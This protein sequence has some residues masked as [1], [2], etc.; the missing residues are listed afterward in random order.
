MEKY[1]ELRE[2]KR[3]ISR[4]EI[5]GHKASL[6]LTAF[7]GRTSANTF[8]TKKMSSVFNLL[9]NEG[10]SHFLSLVEDDEFDN[11]CGK[12]VL[13]A[14]AKKRLINWVHL[15]IGD[16][17]IPKN[18]TLYGLNKIRPQLLEAINRDLSI[19]IHC[20]GGLG[21]SGT[22]AAIIL[23]D[24]GIPLQSAIDRVRQFRPGAIET[25]AQENF[26]LHSSLN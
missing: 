26:V 8:S 16:M 21:R 5:P 24:L 3:N 11:Y 10:C 18:D 14:E 13:E 4:V 12:A 17:D 1:L 6:L 25:K 19:A 20:M 15:P 7:P 23:A 22:I 2:K 9:G